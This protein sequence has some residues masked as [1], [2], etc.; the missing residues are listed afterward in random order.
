MKQEEYPAVVGRRS[1]YYILSSIDFI[2]NTYTDMSGVVA[3]A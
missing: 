2:V 1:S 3:A